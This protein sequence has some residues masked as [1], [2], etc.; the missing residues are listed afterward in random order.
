MP[1]IFQIKQT[2]MAAAQQA[3]GAATDGRNLIADIVDGMLLKMIP[4]KGLASFLAKLVISVANILLAMIWS[5]MPLTGQTSE[6]TEKKITESL[7][8]LE[9]LQE[10]PIGFAPDFQYDNFPQKGRQ[11][12]LVGGPHDGKPWT[13]K[14]D[15]Q[16]MVTFTDGTTYQWDG[17]NPV[18][19]PDE[20]EIPS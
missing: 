6:D 17:F 19:I 10:I 7:L 4:L 20:P 11:Y 9:G 13:C 18:H 14:K 3:Y 2:A 15:R 16:K 1:R 5:K 12:K 8:W